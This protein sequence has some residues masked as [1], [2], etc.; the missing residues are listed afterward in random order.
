VLDR[1][2]FDVPNKVIAIQ[3]ADGG[4][5]AAITGVWT[6]EDP[7]SP[8]SYQARGRWIPHTIDSVECP[9]GTTAEI[10]AFLEGRARATLIQ[11]SAVQAQIKVEHL[12]IP[13]RVSDVLQFAH[14]EARIDS[15]YV[16]T[17]IELDA[18]PIGLMR[19]TLQEVISL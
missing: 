1:D 13:V 4:D 12:P 5:A 10:K 19:S 17:R 6:N 8:Y 3:A 16:I 7:D 2:S 14:T 11:M 15:R 18:T 9:D